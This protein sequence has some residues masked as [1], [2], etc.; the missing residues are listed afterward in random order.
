[1]YC[2]FAKM[3]ETI[4]KLDTSIT[5]SKLR[6][7]IFMFKTIVK[8]DTSITKFYHIPNISRFETIVKLDTSITV[9]T[10]SDAS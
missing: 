9:A 1:M 4:V 5:I 6:N 8:L 3:F 2:S 10:S 7:T